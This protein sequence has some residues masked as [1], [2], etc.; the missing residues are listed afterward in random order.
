[1]PR[2]SNRRPDGAQPCKQH[3]D[4][5]LSLMLLGDFETAFWA[6]SAV[7]ALAPRRHPIW[8][9]IAEFGTAKNAFA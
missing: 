1:M 3:S 4:R 8:P 6:R 9:E 2:R 5:A 7:T